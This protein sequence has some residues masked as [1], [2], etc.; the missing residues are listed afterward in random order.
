MAAYGEI[1]MAA[2]TLEEARATLD[3]RPSPPSKPPPTHS[4]RPSGGSRHGSPRRR[5]RAPGECLPRARGRARRDPRRPLRWPP[6]E[7]VDDPTRTVAM[8]PRHVM[9]TCCSGPPRRALADARRGVR[10]DCLEGRRGRTSEAVSGASSKRLP[11]LGGRSREATLRTSDERLERADLGH[12][13]GI[14]ARAP[15]THR[16]GRD[17]RSSRRHDGGSG[18]WGTAP[19]TWGRGARTASRH[20]STPTTVSRRGASSDVPQHLS[21]TRANSGRVRPL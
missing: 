21:A 14:R 7:V 15:R 11:E 2:V 19:M 4:K 3:R 12:P 1:P 10:E 8:T 9:S 20:P 16:E 18:R 13:R 17:A 6:R 5:P